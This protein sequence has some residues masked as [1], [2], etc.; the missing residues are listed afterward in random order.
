[1]NKERRINVRVNRE[2]ISELNRISR[3]LDLPSSYIVRDAIREKL[4]SLKISDS[5]LQQKSLQ[6][7][8]S[9]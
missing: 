6:V 5:R 3:I 4:D 8:L 9:K 7:E 2:V 1:M